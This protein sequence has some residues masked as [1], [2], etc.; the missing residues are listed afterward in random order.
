MKLHDIKN[1][2]DEHAKSERMPL[3]FVG[4]GNPMNAIEDN[5]FSDAWKKIG[6]EL[7]R[8]QAILSV[9]AHWLTRGSRVLSVAAPRTTAH[10][11]Q[12]ETKYFMTHL[13]RKV[14]TWGI[15][16]QSEGGRRGFAT[17]Y[18]KSR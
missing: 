18:R 17:R 13:T 2:T 10:A 6:R 15:M 1:I 8:P 16:P 7:P 3:L 11:R 4:H 12:K 14:P 9:S 5:R